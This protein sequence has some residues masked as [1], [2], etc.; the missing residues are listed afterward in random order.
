MTA[1]S[2]SEAVT[3][4]APNMAAAMSA[5]TTIASRPYLARPIISSVAQDRVEQDGVILPVAV[6]VEEQVAK[7]GAGLQDR[8]GQ[9][10]DDIL[11]RPGPVDR[12]RADVPADVPPDRAL[13]A[14]RLQDIGAVEPEMIDVGGDAQARGDVEIRADA[15][16]HGPRVD[17]IG[18]PL[19]LGGAQIV[20]DAVALV[21]RDRAA[22]AGEGNGLADPVAGVG[23]GEDRVLEDIV[24]AVLGIVV[25]VAV[26]A[27]EQA[28]P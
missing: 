27:R 10:E 21:E 11:G 28:S 18:L 5:A 16:Q 7:A 19:L 4:D 26:A 15:K 6:I 1:F 14:Q 9:A 2:P 25:G 22:A 24:E 8:A 20:E 17:E 23:S 12:C 3:R 13:H